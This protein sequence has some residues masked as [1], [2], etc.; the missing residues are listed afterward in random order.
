MAELVVASVGF[1]LQ[2][3]DFLFK[4]AKA[5]SIVVQNIEK[6]RHIGPSLY[7]LQVDLCACIARLEKWKEDWGVR[8]GQSVRNLES[9]WGKQG[10]I[11]ILHSLTTIEVTCKALDEDIRKTFDVLEVLGAG[12]EEKR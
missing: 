5:V 6:Y 10:W 8:E 2:S 12:R 1:G 4:A 9:L 3:L 11:N 7:D